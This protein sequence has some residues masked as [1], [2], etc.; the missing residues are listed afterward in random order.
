MSDWRTPSDVQATFSK[1]KILRNDRARFEIGGGG[2]RLV[3]AISYDAGVVNVKFIGTHAEYDR[4]DA[5]TTNL[6]GPPRPL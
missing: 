2:H 6:F 3:A 1:V 4:I 5:E